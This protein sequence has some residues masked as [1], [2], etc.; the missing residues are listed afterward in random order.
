MRQFLLLFGL[1]LSFMITGNIASAQIAGSTAQPAAAGVAAAPAAVAGDNYVIRP[2]DVVEFRVFQEPTMQQQLRVAQDGSV[3]LP[4]VGR[5]TIGGMTSSDAQALIAE[6]YDRDYIVNPQVSLVILSYTERRVFVHG[7]VGIPGPV[8]IQP[9]TQLT[10]AQA[11]SAAGGLTR[12]A[13]YNPIRI[14]RLDKEE[15]I[16]VNFNDVLTDPR[17]KDIPLQDGDIIFVDERII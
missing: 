6:L 13:R 16:Q 9:E 5:V 3:T 1:L 7:Q 15:T 17:T 14:K 11:I 2:L 10:L 4:L 8:L 12:M